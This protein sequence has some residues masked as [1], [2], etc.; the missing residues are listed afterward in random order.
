MVGGFGPLQSGGGLTLEG[1]R[2]N[3]KEALLLIVRLDKERAFKH[4]M[5]EHY[6]AVNA[7]MVDRCLGEYSGL[8]DAIRIVREIAGI[9]HDEYI[10]ALVD[11]EERR[12]TQY[13]D[14]GYPSGYKSENLVD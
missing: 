4:K 14:I 12:S 3:K 2:M 7:S 9:S 1:Y 13:V 6:K 5:S 11:A 8:D 10:N